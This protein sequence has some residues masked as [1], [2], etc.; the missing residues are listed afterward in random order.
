MTHFSCQHQR[1]G[2]RPIGD[3]RSHSPRYSRYSRYSTSWSRSGGCIRL[4]G[5]ALVVCMVAVLAVF[6][7]LATPSEASAAAAPAAQTG[8]QSCS[9]RFVNPLGDAAVVRRFEQPLTSWGPG[10]RGIDLASAQGE[11]IRAPAAGSIS[12]AGQVAGKSVVSID[13]GF[14]K[15]TFE[16]AVTEL[17]LGTVLGQGE[18]F[19]IVSGGSDHCGT[20]CL[21]WGLQTDDGSY[22]DPEQALAVTDIVLKAG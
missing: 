4:A 14:L 16:P 17:G 13:H 6:C 18:A 9:A 19:G 20:S 2:H 1:P 12:F 5:A 10:H 11:T 8:S 22:R 7:L 15:S 21:H 3:V